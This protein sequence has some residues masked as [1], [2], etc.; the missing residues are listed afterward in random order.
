MP[1]SVNCCHI[2]CKTTLEKLL[3]IDGKKLASGSD[4]EYIK[5]TGNAID[6]AI[7][8]VD[9]RQKQVALFMN[10]IKMQQLKTITDAGEKMPQKSTFFYPKVFTGL[11][12]NKL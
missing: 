10:P 9:G 3:G 7:A 2:E 12:I 6:E 8:K 5:G 4:V 1:S 11:T